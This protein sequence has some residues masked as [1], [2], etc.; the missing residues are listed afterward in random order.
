MFNNKDIYKYFNININ[1]KI[2][3][4]SNFKNLIYSD[5]GVIKLSLPKKN[6]IVENKLFNLF[7]L[8]NYSLFYKQLVPNANYALFYIKNLSN[9]IILI[10]AR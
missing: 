8:F 3:S 9:Q 1:K 10:D 5:N 6:K 4:N 2:N 7:F